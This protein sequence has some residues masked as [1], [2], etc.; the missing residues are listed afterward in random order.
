MPA[1]RTRNAAMPMPDFTITPTPTSPARVNAGSG[2]LFR[3]RQY[4]AF[5]VRDQ[6]DDYSFIVQT[7]SDKRGNESDGK[8]CEIEALL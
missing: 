1:E 7:T 2:E 5:L 3:A 8:R 4:R 6:C